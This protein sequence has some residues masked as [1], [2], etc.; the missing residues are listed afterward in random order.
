M[1]YLDTH[2]LGYQINA[3]ERL[4]QEKV[5]AFSRFCPGFW[6]PPEES[7]SLGAYEL[8]TPLL[9]HHQPIS[10]RAAPSFKP[11]VESSVWPECLPVS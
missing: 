3:A 5:S 2:S 10:Q 7:L 6:K 8:L 4:S 1:I 11:S 9:M